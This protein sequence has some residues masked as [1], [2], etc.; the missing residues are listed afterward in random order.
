MEV[1]VNTQHHAEEQEGMDNQDL[2]PKESVLM[3]VDLDILQPK[4]SIASSS[5]VSSTPSTLTTKKAATT[6]KPLGKTNRSDVRRNTYGKPKGK[7]KADVYEAVTT[8]PIIVNKLGVCTKEETEI[9]Q[10]NLVVESSTVNSEDKTLNSSDLSE[11]A[12]H[13][14]NVVEYPALVKEKSAKSGRN[15]SADG[16]MDAIIPNLGAKSTPNHVIGMPGSNK[17]LSQK[18]RKRLMNTSC[19]ASDEKST[20]INSNPWSLKDHPPSS[21]NAT[22]VNNDNYTGPSMNGTVSFTAIQETEDAIRKNSY[23]K[24]LS[25]NNSINN[26]WYVERKRDSDMS[27]ATIMKI[28]EILNGDN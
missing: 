15:I 9:K 4:L 20:P 26:P 21:N 18:E 8:Q 17:R 13:S 12:Q 14:V 24:Q 7:N 25:G 11:P 19:T 23:M 5:V 22:S 28:Q 3:S 16:S 6:T 10:I 27:F 2:L 1:L